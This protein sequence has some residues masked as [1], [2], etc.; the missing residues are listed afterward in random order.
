MLATQAANGMKHLMTHLEAL[1]HEPFLEQ[2]AEHPPHAL[3]EIWVQSLVII[4]KA[5]PAPNALHSLLP[6]LGVPVDR[7]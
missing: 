3:H 4:L 6:L 1:V 5:N 2:G 7:Q